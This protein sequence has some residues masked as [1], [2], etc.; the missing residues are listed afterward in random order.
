MSNPH[1]LIISYPAQGHVRPLLEFSQLL[2]KHGI[3]VTF[4]N[5]EFA[6]QQIMN[7]FGIKVS[8]DGSIRFVSLLGG[9]GVD[10][11]RNQ[12]GRLIESICQFMPVELKQLIE[13]INRSDG[14]E[15]ICLLTDMT[16]GWPL[17]VAVELGIKAA[18]LFPA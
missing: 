5:T 18:A 12:I 16:I 6:H 4:M 10:E 8:V 7:A 9:M 13:E 3:K 17:K 14:D 11:N 1:I 15:V 2:V